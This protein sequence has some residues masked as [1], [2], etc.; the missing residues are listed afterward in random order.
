MSQESEET[1]SDEETCCYN[2]EEESDID[3]RLSPNGEVKWF[4]LFNMSGP[5]ITAPCSHSAEECPVK[6][7]HRKLLARKHRNLLARQH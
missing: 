2:D 7:K 3:W 5:N 6:I 4:S 1:H